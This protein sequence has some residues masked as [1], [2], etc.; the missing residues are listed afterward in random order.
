V[1][2]FCE[3]NDDAVTPSTAALV[4]ELQGDFDKYVPLEPPSQFLYYTN[5]F[6]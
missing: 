2:D 5:N 6:P 4:S 1:L 3:T